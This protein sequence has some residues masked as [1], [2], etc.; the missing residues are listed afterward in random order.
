M[1]TL[2][3][4]GSGLLIVS[5]HNTMNAPMGFT[6]DHVLVADFKL[7]PDKYQTAGARDRFFRGLRDELAPIPGVS[8]IAATRLLPLNTELFVPVVTEDS[9]AAGP[10]ELRLLTAPNVTSDY[11]QAMGIPL[12]RGAL[13]P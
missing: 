3:A 4:I 11:F 10:I 1:G 6:A 7:P 2:L 9:E 5:L 13:F 8:H 12:A